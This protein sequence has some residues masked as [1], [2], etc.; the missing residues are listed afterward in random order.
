M[1]S[2][3]LVNQ[4]PIIQ[5]ITVITLFK[6]IRN[7]SIECNKI[8]HMGI[9]GTKT[10]AT[11][12][13]T[14]DTMNESMAAIAAIAGSLGAYEPLRAQQVTRGYVKQL[15]RSVRPSPCRQ[16]PLIFSFFFFHKISTFLLKQKHVTRALTSNMAETCSSSPHPLCVSVSVA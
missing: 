5:F 7:H 14:S 11:W 3:S 2:L 4:L 10:K 6:R 12:L 1:I 9:D 13:I 16:V 8:G 15:T